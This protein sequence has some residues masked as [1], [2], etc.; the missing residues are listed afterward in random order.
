MNCKQHLGTVPLLFVLILS[1][2]LQGTASRCIDT[3]FG[4]DLQPL[5]PGVERCSFPTGLLKPDVLPPGQGG[6]SIE[7]RD[8]RI[9]GGRPVTS[10]DYGGGSSAAHS[11]EHNEIQSGRPSGPWHSGKP[12]GPIFGGGPAQNGNAKDPRP[13]GL[14]GDA[15]QHEGGTPGGSPSGFRIRYNTR[16]GHPRPVWK[17]PGIP[18]IPT[19][20][21]WGGSYIPASK[22]S[23]Q[24]RPSVPYGGDAGSYDSGQQYSPTYDGKS[25]ASGPRGRDDGSYGPIPEA[26]QPGGQQGRDS[27]P[28]KNPC[29]PNC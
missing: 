19:P 13:Y 9:V 12:M 15:G 20:Q 3:S 16:E 25:I 6:N 1:F 11:Q 17:D 29:I 18:Y 8:S 10:G 26:L 22:V 4:Q 7:G 5:P 28:P 21:E 14:G 27:I 2:H 24:Y 23:P